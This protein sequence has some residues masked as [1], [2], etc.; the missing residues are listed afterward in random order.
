MFSKQQIKSNDKALSKQRIPKPAGQHL[1]I[2]TQQQ[3]H[4]ATII[5]RVRLDPNSLTSRDILQLQRTIGNQAVQGLLTPKAK[6]SAGTQRTGSPLRTKVHEW[7]YVARQ[8][9]GVSSTRIDRA[10]VTKRTQSTVIQRSSTPVPPEVWYFYPGLNVS[11]AEGIRGL[12]LEKLAEKGEIPKPRKIKDIEDIFTELGSCAHFYREMYGQKLAPFVSELH[13]VG[14][15][16]R[17]AIAFG[18]YMYDADALSKLS[19]GRGEGYL[20]EGVRIYLDGCTVAAGTAGDKF[21]YQVGRVFLGSK[22]GYLLGNTCEVFPGGTRELSCNPKK[23]KY[24]A[25]F[26]NLVDK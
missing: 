1:D 23:D 16:R 10:E 5:Q 12:E 6:Q 19:T 9:S 7:T 2:L 25:Y 17:G 20:K 18:G 24:P 8:M 26:R 3:T 15:G 22:T 14:E 13:V 4:L 11:P 21:M